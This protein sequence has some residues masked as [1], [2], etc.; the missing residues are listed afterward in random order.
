MAEHFEKMANNYLTNFLPDPKEAFVV[1]LG[2]ND[3]IM[4]LY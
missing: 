4:F 3:G 1:E 2:S